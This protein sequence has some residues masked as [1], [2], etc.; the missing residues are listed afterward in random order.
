MQIALGTAQFGMRYGVAGRGEPVPEDEIRSILE[1][2][3][4]HGIRVLDTAAAYGDIEERLRALTGGLE[5]RIVSKI[6]PLPADADA[7]EKARFVAMVIERSRERLGDLLSAVMF[8]RATDLQD[9]G[10]R[11]AWDRAEQICGAA[12]LMLGVSCYSPQELDVLRS[13]FPIKIAQLP[14]NALDQRTAQAAQ[15]GRLAGLEVHM[16]SVFLQGLLL[17]SEEEAAPR[18]PAAEGAIREWRRWCAERNL[19]PLRAAIAIAKSVTDVKCLVI[20]VDRPAQLQEILQAWEQSAPIA[21]PELASSEL[22]VIDPR[23][24]QQ[25]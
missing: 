1:L 22:D 15:A 19:S 4:A 3:H 18:V 5:F 9:A 23:R 25:R 11:T 21:A 2:A 8:H 20:G 10:A 24:W 17:L 6:P 12:G 14:G 16:R 13:Q 7:D